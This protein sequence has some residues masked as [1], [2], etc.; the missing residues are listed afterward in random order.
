GFDGDGS[1][2]DLGGGRFHGLGGRAGSLGLG[3]RR[4]RLC[5]G[6]GGSLFRFLGDP[7]VL[8]VLGDQG[9]DA[10]LT[11][12]AAAVFVDALALG[13]GT[14]L[15]G[16]HRL[17]G[18]GP[19]S[20]GPGDFLCPGFGLTARAALGRF[21]G[22]GGFLLGRHHSGFARLAFRLDANLLAHLAALA[23]L[24][25]HLLFLLQIQFLL[26]DRSRGRG[27]D[28]GQFDG[29]GFLLLRLGPLLGLLVAAGLAP[30][31]AGLVGFGFR[32]GLGLGNRRLATA[33][34]VTRLAAASIAAALASFAAL[35]ATG[36]TGRFFG[37]RPP[38]RRRP[39][40][41]P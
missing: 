3:D 4:L 37:R 25:H 1:R 10:L 33:L 40:R 20:L 30:F 2:L 5:Y 12:L 16:Q 22:V 21:P 31:A 27:G 13:H 19:L 14:A 28:Q 38:A 29:G 18:L 24:G 32:L 34:F 15:V 8:T 11:T 6:S 7:F 26:L 35:I 39:R 9:G 17:A 36:L 41:A 23:T